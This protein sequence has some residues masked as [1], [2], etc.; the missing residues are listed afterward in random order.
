[1]ATEQIPITPA[2]V[3]WGRERAGLTVE[4]AAEHFARITDWENGASFPT[5]P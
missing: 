3:R 4:A 5:Y 1:M 2:L